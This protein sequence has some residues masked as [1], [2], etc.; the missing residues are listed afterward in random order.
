VATTSLGMPSLPP[1]PAA[2]A[3]RTAW[4]AALYGPDGFFRR[5]APADH[6]RT[7]VHGSDLMARAL[8]RLAQAKG[9]DAVVDVGAGRGELLVALHRLAPRLRLVG[10]EVA[11]RP[12]GLPAEI[13]WQPVLPAALEGLVVA[14]E[15]LDNVPCHVVEVDQTGTPRLV[16]V[17]PATGTE[18]LGL[19]VDAPGVPPG[20]GQWLA[21]WW[22]LDGASPGARAEVGTARDRAWKDVVDRLSR[23]V[24]VA[25][26]YGHTRDGRPLLG[27]LRSYRDGRQVPVVPDGLRDV[28]A[29]LA[30]DA[31]A[32][33]TSGQ[34]H[35][36]REALLALGVSAERPPLA[37]ASDQPGQYAAGLAR[38]AA[39]AELLAPDG[40][41]GF[42]WMVS[43]AGGVS[44]TLG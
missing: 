6:F 33:A 19:A 9:L 10:I 2:P 18:S 8:L 39:A 14:H 22:P 43:G 20:I 15:W 27:S 1:R 23:G 3:W 7:A 21:Q 12:S 41:G 37:Q 17:D 30:V 34:I 32:A 29:D 28:T 42:Y 26:D 38:S 35:S 36:Q 25:V 11:A 44:P 13:G 31:V 16:H 4:D 24:T 40:F 5:A